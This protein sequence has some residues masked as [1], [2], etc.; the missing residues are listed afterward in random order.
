MIHWGSTFLQMTS[1]MADFG[2]LNCLI[3]SF[4]TWPCTCF[5]HLHPLR[6]LFPHRGTVCSPHRLALI[7]RRGVVLLTCQHDVVGVRCRNRSR[8]P[9]SE[10]TLWP[11]TLA[12]VVARWLVRQRSRRGVMPL[13]CQ[14]DHADEDSIFLAIC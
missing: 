7:G 10:L 5:L 11:Q 4:L 9:D 2:P 6:R 3:W 14:H 1:L 13:P 12:H 8:S